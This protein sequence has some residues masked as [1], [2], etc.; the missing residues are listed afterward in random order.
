M[1]LAGSSVAFEQPVDTVKFDRIPFP[2]ISYDTAFL[3]EGSSGMGFVY[4]FN[5]MIRM[6]RLL[7][8]PRSSEADSA[9]LHHRQASQESRR[10]YRAVHRYHPIGGYPLRAMGQSRPE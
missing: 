6:V 10:C 4:V 5:P 1:G 9:Y 3:I 2:M 7:V 8:C